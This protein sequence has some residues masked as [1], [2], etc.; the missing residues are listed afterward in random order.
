[1]NN[2]QMFLPNNL[3]CCFPEYGIIGNYQNLDNLGS[4][5]DFLER[6]SYDGRRYTNKAVV[7][8]AACSVVNNDSED[9]W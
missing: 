7:H 5:T 2:N 8:K 3:I 9:E 4:A 6:V 1:M